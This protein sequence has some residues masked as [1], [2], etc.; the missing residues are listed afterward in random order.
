MRT[1]SYLWSA[2]RVRLACGPS[3]AGAQHDHDHMHEAPER[4]GQVT[5]PISSP[6]AQ[7]DFT[8]GLALLHSFAY[9]SGGDGVQRRRPRKTPKLRHG[10]MGVAMTYFPY[11]LGTAHGGRVRLWDGPRPRKAAATRRADAPRE[12]DYRSPRSA[13]LP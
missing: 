5:F 7:A 2:I 6:A 9:P 13:L 3:S 4:L 12:R 10:A 11:D 8:H 1:R